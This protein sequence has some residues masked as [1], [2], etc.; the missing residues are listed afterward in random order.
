MVDPAQRSM[1]PTAMT[2]IIAD[3][4]ATGM[5][6]RSGA[7]YKRRSTSVTVVVTLDKSLRPPTR[8][9]V[10]AWCDE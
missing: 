2:S 9:V 8:C 6:C 1:R 5:S 10:I 7:P 4:A 3:S